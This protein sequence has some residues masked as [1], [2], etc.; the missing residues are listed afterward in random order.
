MNYNIYRGEHAGKR[1]ETTKFQAFIAEV[2]AVCEKHGISLSHSQGGFILEPYNLSSFVE[3]AD[4][5][6][7]WHDGL[8]MAPVPCID[9]DAELLDAREIQ[10]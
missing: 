9:E 6:V 10:L 5:L 4:A 2:Q 7:F 8:R 3:I 1:I